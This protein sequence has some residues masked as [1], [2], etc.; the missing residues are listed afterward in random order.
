MDIKNPFTLLALL[1]ALPGAYLAF[2][3]S[4]PD[5]LKSQMV[6]RG[7]P[8]GIGQKTVRCSY[9]LLARLFLGRKRNWIGLF[10]STSETA[11]VFTEDKTIALRM[12]IW[13]SLV[14]I[15]SFISW[16]KSS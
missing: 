11:K 12:F 16:I 4:F 6:D 7:N 13:F 1:S 10:S 15:F 2:K 8:S 14:F 9:K 3:K 5:D